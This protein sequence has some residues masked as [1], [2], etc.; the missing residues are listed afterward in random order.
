M[1]RGSQ[2][3]LGSAL[4]ALVAFVA[5]PLWADV[6]TEFQPK[7]DE[8]F[9]LGYPVGYKSGLVS[10]KTRGRTE[11]WTNGTND[12]QND[13]W[14]AA[15]QPAYDLAYDARYPRG[16]RAGWK[17]GVVEGFEKGFDYAPT[18]AAEILNNWYNGG[19]YWSGI[20]MVSAGTFDISGLGLYSGDYT[21]WRDNLGY[22]WAKHF[23]DEGFTDGR[24]E[25]FTVGSDEG[26][27]L[28]YPK[29]YAAAYPIGYVSG[30]WDGTRDG[31]RQGGEQGYDDG[32]DTGYDTGYDEGFVAGV[33][34]HLFGEFERPKYVLEFTRRSDASTRQTL[35]AVQAPEPASLVLVGLAVGAGL[36]LRPG[37]GRCG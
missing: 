26:Y 27:N 14:E 28:T 10:G 19:N 7:Y 25:G 34:Y 33:D 22:D 31:T 30:V 17:D 35:L 18:I 12:G 11:G 13:G 29:A 21:V 1:K 4:V 23:Y 37:R 9:D 5:S 24:T 15:F 32:W 3:A 8:G 16:H 20:T 2:V 6:P 36:L